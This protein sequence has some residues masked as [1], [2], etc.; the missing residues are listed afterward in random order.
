MLGGVIA[1]PLIAGAMGEV[2]NSEP[3]WWPT[4]CRKNFWQKSLILSFLLLLHQLPK[5]QEL[6]IL[7]L[8]WCEIAIRKPNRRNFMM[9][10]LN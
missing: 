4:I 2:L 9:D 5:K 7:S 1:V 10:W 8:E 3:G 6:I